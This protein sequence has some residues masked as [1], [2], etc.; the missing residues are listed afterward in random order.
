MEFGDKIQF[1][2]FVIAVLYGNSGMMFLGILLGDALITES[3]VVIWK[4]LMKRIPERY[5]R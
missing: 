3:G 5:L 1:A 4:G 2:S